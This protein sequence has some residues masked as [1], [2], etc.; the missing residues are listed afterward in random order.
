MP[1]HSSNRAII[2]LILCA[3]PALPALSGC[4]PLGVIAAKMPPPTI[5][6]KYQ[7]GGQSVGVMV[8]ADQGVLIDW[9]S[10]QLDV[11]N[12]VQKLLAA[13]KD[14]EMKGAT[15]PV[16][17][18]SIVRWQ[19][20]HPES[21][22][23]PVTMIAPRLGVSRLIYIEV[24]NFATRS[25]LTVDLYRGL[26]TATVKV[27]EVK[28]GKADVGFA[29]NGVRAAFPPKAPREGVPNAGDEK[30]Y[31]GTVAGLSAEVGKIF[32]RHEEEE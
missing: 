28:D 15:F 13:S 12:S 16:Q 21:E 14:K 19:Q 22:G 32:L 9:P 3:L 6:P 31:Y 11:A 18:A 4:V 29:E 10:L 17:P 7:L 8:W 2:L 26:A 30:I 20:D 1:N 27:F 5:L 23:S 25:D 24:E